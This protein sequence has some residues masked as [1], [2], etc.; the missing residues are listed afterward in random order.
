MTN[1]PK[2]FEVAVCKTDKEFRVTVCKQYEFSAAHDLPL[3]PE[4]HRCRNLHGHNYVVEVEV[5]ASVLINGMVM[6]F[7]GLDQIMEEIIKTIDHRYLNHIIGL[8]NPTAENISIWIGKKVENRLRFLLN[9]VNLTRL[10]VY[11]TPT[12]WAELQY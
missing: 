6:D 8:E 1:S 10:R 2:D 9:N 7:F 4:N 5:N 11:E 3:V 12:C